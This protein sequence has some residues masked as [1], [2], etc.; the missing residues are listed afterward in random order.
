[1]KKFLNVLKII[2][3]AILIILILV[4]G[5]ILIYNKVMES[6]EEVYW[7]NPPGQMVE[8]D[9][10]KMHIYS[11]GKGEQ[12]IVF[13][14]GWGDTSPYQQFLPLCKALNKDFRVV[15]IEKFGYGLSDTVDGNRDVETVLENDR[16]ALSAAGID[17]PFILC[18]HSLSGLEATLW[19][20]NYPEEVKGIVGMDISVKENKYLEETELEKQQRKIMDRYRFFR[21]TGLLRVLDNLEANILTEDDKMENAI[22]YRSLLNKTQMSEDANINSDCDVIA[23]KPLPS[24]PTVQYVSKQTIE[25]YPLWGKAHKALV[26]ASVDGQYIEV[27]AS[28]Y[29][30]KEKPEL[31]ID[32]IREFAN[33]L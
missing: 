24:V 4:E 12:T 13:M 16:E 14:S 22:V 26:D 7:Q 1:M 28:H 9:G 15:I 11:E 25:M 32:G 27:D 21:A 6:K 30:Y 29:I 3:L 2:L 5:V 17:G 18:P 33:K 10:H 19:A 23:S 20:Q 31:I 8:V